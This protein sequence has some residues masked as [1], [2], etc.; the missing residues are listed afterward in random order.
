MQ[1]VD[2]QWVISPQDLVSELEC[3]QRV[4]LNAAVQQGL[5]QAPRGT[6]PMLQLLQRRGLKHEGARLKDLSGGLRVFEVE[7]SDNRHP[8]SW[9]EAWRETERAMLD[10]HDVIY[11]ATLFKGDFI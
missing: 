1:I 6:D 9:G 8:D 4:A 10:E 7:Q 11:Q 5:L 3:Q 2:G